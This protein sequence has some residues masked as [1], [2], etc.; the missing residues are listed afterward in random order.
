MISSKAGAI[1]QY[2]SVCKATLD[3]AVVDTVQSDEVTW[4]KCPRCNGILPHMMS[5]DETRSTETPPAPA[6]QAAAAAVAEAE[7]PAAIPE[8]ERQDA[9][10]YDPAQTYRVGE[11]VYHRSINQYGRIL[12]KTQLPGRRAVIRVQFET[13]GEPMTLREAQ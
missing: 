5:R 9:R 3:M 11:I 2:C 13:G 10:D 7:A 6:P 4:L 12:E 1:K 8:S